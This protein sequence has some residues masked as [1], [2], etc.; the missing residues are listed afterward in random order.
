MASRRP[1]WLL[2][3][4]TVG[5]DDASVERAVQAIAGHCAAGGIAVAATHLALPVAGAIRLQ[6]GTTP[7]PT[8]A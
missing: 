3:E 5:F 8:A 2:D 1:V 7:T 6:L 4:P